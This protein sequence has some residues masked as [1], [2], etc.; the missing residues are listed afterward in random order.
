MNQPLSIVAITTAVVGRE[1][2]LRAAQEKLVAETL[3]E[4]GCLRYELNQSL[5]DGRMLVFTEQWASEPEW[6]AH[7]EGRA[8]RRFAAS[9][10]PKFIADFKLFRLNT[11]AGGART[12]PKT[13]RRVEIEGCVGGDR[14]HVH[15]RT[16]RAWF[17]CRVA[18]GPGPR[19]Y[20]APVDQF[21][22]IE[23]GEDHSGAR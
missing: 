3:T 6:R 13:R 9:G 4:P 19:R 20:R 2:E 1:K 22:R 18:R 7:M 23:V 15:A 17:A 5:E 21:R 11:V 10:A 14:A 8:I 16:R 12:G